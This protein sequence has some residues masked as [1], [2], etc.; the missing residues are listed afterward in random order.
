[1][2]DVEKELASIARENDYWSTQIA[3]AQSPTELRSRSLNKLKAPSAEKVIYA[4]QEFDAANPGR[5]RIVA[6]YKK[7][8]T[9]KT[10]QT[11]RR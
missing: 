5:T 9:T 4:Y 1:M 3:K 11:A 2:R 8:N 6:S 7:T 10:V